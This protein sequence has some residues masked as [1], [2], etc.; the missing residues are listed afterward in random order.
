MQQITA[1]PTELTQKGNSVC[2]ALTA[3]IPS[4]LSLGPS[5][6]S[7]PSTSPVSALAVVGITQCTWQGHQDPKMTYFPLSQLQSCSVFPLLL[8]WP[9]HR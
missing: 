2:P 9:A 6:G 1:Q 5:S 4:L 8:F 3:H 7:C